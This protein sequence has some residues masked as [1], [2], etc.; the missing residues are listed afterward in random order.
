MS[1]NNV[2]WYLMKHDDRMVFGP[3]P[4]SQL[5]TW[6]STAQVS[7][8]D[9]VST[10]EVNWVKAPMLADLE[11]DY[12]IHVSD[13]Q[14]YGPTTLGA[15]KEFIA[16][17]EIGE[18]TLITNCKDGHEQRAGDIPGL[19]PE[20][21]EQPLR[22]SIRISLQARVRELEEALMDERRAREAAQARCEKLE[23]KLASLGANA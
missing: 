12:L 15:V 22:T 9:K 23:A 10:D 19:F 8:L 11:M 7:P 18:E 5:H 13:E 16:V 4:F 14:Y 1:D 21:E 6:A 17:G 3:V 20:Q 2:S